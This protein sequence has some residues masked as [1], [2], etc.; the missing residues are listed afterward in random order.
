MWDPQLPALTERFHVVRYDRRGHGRSRV[1][2][3]PYTID[4]L[5]GD[6]LE[7]LD[8]L[9]LERVSFCGRSIGGAGGMWLAVH[10]PAR[11]ERLVLCCTRPAFP[12]PEQWAERAAVVREGDVAAVADAALGRWFTPPF[13][14]ARPDVVDSFRTMLVETPAEGYAACCEALGALD[15]RPRLVAITV[16]TLVVTG[17]DDPVAPPESGEQLAAAIPGARHE[18]VAGAAHIANVE[19]PAVFTELL[20]DHLSG[21]TS[22]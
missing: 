13:H 21:G 19:Q 22:T 14:L 2:A 12:P 11:V 3:G 6:V 1:P 20:L 18:V 16:P 7:L 15:L 8:E 9:G 5:G 10:A 17:E 4:D